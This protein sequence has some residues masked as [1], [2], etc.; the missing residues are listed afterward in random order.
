MTLS[1][2]SI[3]SNDENSLPKTQTPTIEARNPHIE[4]VFDSLTFG[5]WVFRKM[6]YSKLKERDSYTTSFG[7]RYSLGF[8]KKNLTLNFGTDYS[9]K[10]DGARIGSWNYKNRRIIFTKDIQ[11]HVE[12]P[13]LFDHSYGVTIVGNVMTLSML[14][15]LDEPEKSARIQFILI[16]GNKHPS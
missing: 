8:D 9:L 6:S 1:S 10:F 3:Q 7:D 4:H 13:L 5:E 15:N 11:K 16:S 2:C 14:T 12:F